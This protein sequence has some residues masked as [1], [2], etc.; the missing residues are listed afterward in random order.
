MCFQLLLH[1]GVSN[2]HEILSIIILGVEGKKD[3]SWKIKKVKKSQSDWNIH[4]SISDIH[5][6][7]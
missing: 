3:P 5:T 2:S 7:P 6:F 4:E 1:V